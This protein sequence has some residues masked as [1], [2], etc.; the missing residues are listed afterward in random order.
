VACGNIL[1]DLYEGLIAEDAAGRPIPGMAERWET[2][3]DGL[4]WTFH[5]RAGLRWS[6]GQPLDAEQIVASFRR[7][8]DPA[9]GAPMAMQFAAIDNAIAIL[10]G[11]RD[12][13]AL[14]VHAPDARTVEFRLIRPAP[15]ESLLTLPLAYPVWLTGIAA[16]GDRHTRAGHLVSNGAYRLHAWTPQSSLRLRAN[17][18]YHAAVAIDEVG[19]HVTEDAAAERKRFEAGDL[20]VTETAPPGRQAEL[21]R[22]FGDALRIEPYLG[23]FWLG[24]NLT[25]PPFADN[26]ALREALSLA[27]DRDILTRAITGMDESPA[28]GIVPPGIGS[29]RNPSPPHADWTQAQRDALARQRYAEAG[30]S[31]G[32]PLRVELR[33]N[34]SLPHRRTLL[35]V[36][37]MW[38]ET[39]G[40]HSELRNEEWKVFVQNRRQR[41]LTQ[42]FRGG[43]IA[44]VADP[45]DFLGGF[46][47]DTAL[48]WTGY[49]NPAFS[50]VLR[51]AREAADPATRMR[52]A[53]EAERLLLDDHAV[54]ALYHYTSKHLVDPRLDGWIG[55][56]LDRHPSRFLRWRDVESSPD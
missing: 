25:R 31:R 47:G 30:Y 6:D 2:S 52:L 12:P 18:H 35:A 50:A 16:H 37:A 11:E 45:L 43:W 15:L 20:H 27:V 3:A 36:S 24:L 8:L 33:Y 10:R 34:S 4:R 55:N 28:W 38:R 7:A 51:E 29:Y 44:D 56:P 46:D 42:V 39:L 23:S 14:G 1:R 21:R 53:A 17:P 26:R 41:V 5:L 48:N 13:G 22:R 32:R 9:T 19:Y 49:H 40:V 54:I